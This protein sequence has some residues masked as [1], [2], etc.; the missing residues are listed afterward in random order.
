M[1]I[2]LHLIEGISY[3]EAVAK[4]VIH[5]WKRPHQNLNGFFRTNIR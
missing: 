4:A 2:S 1:L 5:D 3:V